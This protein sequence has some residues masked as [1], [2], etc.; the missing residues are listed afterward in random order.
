[1]SCPKAVYQWNQ[2]VVKQMPHLSKPQAHV[3]ALWS[4]GMILSRSCALSAVSN[5][6]AAALGRKENSVRSQLR[7]WCYE[8][9]AKSGQQRCELEVESCFG[10][11]LGWVLSLWQGRQIALA[12]DATSLND[13]FVV[14]CVSVLFRG[15]AIP[16]AWRVLPA[17]QK[18]AWRKEWL[19]LLRVLKPC[20]PP[21]YLVIVLADRGLYARWLF[22]RI[23]R[24]GWHPF[25]R[26]KRGGSFCPHGGRRARMQSFVGQVGGCWSGRGVAFTRK[27]ELECT[28]LAFWEKGCAEPWLILTDLP[29]QAGQAAWYGMRAWI[30]C[31]FKIT[32]SGGWQWHKTKMSD[33]Q[34]AE[35]LWLAV[36]VATLWVLALGGE[37]EDQLPTIRN[38]AGA[39]PL[40]K[41]S[42]CNE[43]GREVDLAALLQA[44]APRQRKATQARLVSVFRRGL[45]RVLVALLNQ[46]KVPQ[47][48]LKPEPW[49]ALPPEQISLNVHQI[50][51]EIL[52]A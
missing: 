7:E 35:R 45:I 28:L 48:S 4:W 15:C 36:A 44:A 20:L 39:R 25:L 38:D 1:M 14:L 37:A 32:K 9:S 2:M 18:R 13:R 46:H 27:R 24:L 19:A 23:V 8:T 3:L 41:C 21:S 16:V 51:H 5:F 42:L 31:G 12:L 10:P 50:E 11:L 17:N 33:P 47:G 43:D 29:P 34:R 30:E 49:P 40:P 52:L 6:L 22:R 26:V